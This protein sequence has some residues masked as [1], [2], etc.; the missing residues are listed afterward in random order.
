MIN[1]GTIFFHEQFVLLVSIRRAPLKITQYTLE[2]SSFTKSV[3]QSLRFLGFC[4]VTCASCDHT[5]R[6]VNRCSCPSPNWDASIPIICPKNRNGIPPLWKEDGWNRQRYFIVF[7]FNNR[8]SCSNRWPPQIAVPN[9]PESSMDEK[10]W[11]SF[12]QITLL[13]KQ[14]KSSN[15]SLGTMTHLFGIAQT[16]L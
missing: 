6:I 12:L 16:T 9:Q 15:P 2:Q 10:V 14:S 1:I 7:G 4:T 8:W 3:C 13:K 5:G 11:R